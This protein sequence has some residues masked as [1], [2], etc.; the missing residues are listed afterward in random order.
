MRKRGLSRGKSRGCKVAPGP[1]NA[2]M[3][4]KSSQAPL[5]DIMVK[6]NTHDTKKENDDQELENVEGKKALFGALK[7]EDDQET[8]TIIQP[9]E[10]TVVDAF[11]DGD[12][13]IGGG[14][15]RASAQEESA[16]Q[17]GQMA[18]TMDGNLIRIK[19]ERP[20]LNRG[21][22]D[23]QSLL[24]S[25]GDPPEPSFWTRFRSVIL[26]IIFAIYVI[27]GYFFY[28]HYLGWN[29][30]EVMFFIML[31]CTTVGYGVDLETNTATGEK[32]EEQDWLM[33]LAFTSVFAVFGVFVVFGM[34]LSTYKWALDRAKHVKIAAAHAS[35]FLKKTSGASRIGRA[36][37]KGPFSTTRTNTLD[38]GS[39]A[40]ANK[41]RRCCGCCTVKLFLRQ[42]WVLSPLVALVLTG[43]VIGHLEDPR[44][45]P[46]QSL[47]VSVMT[48][49]TIGYGDYQPEHMNTMIVGIFYLPLAVCA[50][51][52]VIGS[53]QPDSIET[54]LANLQNDPEKLLEVLKRA[55]ARKFKRMTNPN[56]RSTVIQV[57]KADYVI[58]MLLE[59]TEDI[60]EDAIVVMERHFDSLD[61]DASGTLDEHEI[62]RLVKKHRDKR[63]TRLS[64]TSPKKISEE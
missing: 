16:R 48:L 24:A 2:A 53:L 12:E 44:W 4:S 13:V 22:S 39:P 58:A 55:H 6:Q 31:T 59:L 28:H 25:L 52:S 49:T 10:A 14:E 36:I 19:S 45:H 61:D 60:K 64:R 56:S 50:A 18:S 7:S 51:A 47:Y 3:A 34:I 38:A 17:D 11:E 5:L 26:V 30:V 57:S 54:K 1:S 8:T 35:A 29:F 43:L 9:K 20:E 23:R 33:C 46:A 42:L 21:M 63:E 32:L 41:E 27:V 15:V 37:S 62:Y 40:K